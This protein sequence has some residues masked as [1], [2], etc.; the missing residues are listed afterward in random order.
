MVF[1][2]ATFNGTAAKHV[3]RPLKVGFRCAHE[4]RT[5]RLTAGLRE[6]AQVGQA[7][8]ANAQGFVYA[9]NAVSHDPADGEEGLEFPGCCGVEGHA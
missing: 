8:R 4:Q 5:L 6:E 2:S 9:D 1:T 7:L 3:L